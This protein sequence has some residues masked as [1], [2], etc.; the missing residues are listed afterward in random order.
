[1]ALS[2]RKSFLRKPPLLDLSHHHIRPFPPDGGKN[3]DIYT[4]C[5]NNK[6]PPT[7][8]II[9]PPQ[10]RPRLPHS[11]P[12]SAPSS[13]TTATTSSSPSSPFPDQ[14]LGAPATHAITSVRTTAWP[15]VRMV[16]PA[17]S[18]RRGTQPK[19]WRRVSGACSTFHTPVCWVRERQGVRGRLLP[20]GA[21]WSR[22]EAT[23]M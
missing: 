11:A 15:H 6:A 2:S 22:E 19:C 21:A 3:R 14:G 5:F 4:P 8:T 18:S 12:P 9:T 13:H 7:P 17:C 16:S 10:S 23:G 20:R 1:M